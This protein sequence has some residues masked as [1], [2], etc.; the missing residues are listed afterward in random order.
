MNKIDKN[1]YNRLAKLAAD[2]DTAFIELYEKF[3]PL[4]YGMIF[5]RI[6]DVS[7]SDDVVSEIFFKV[8]QNLHTYNDKYN[9]SAW[10][11]AIATNTLINHFRK[12]N[13]RRE[14]SWAEFFDSPA[15]SNDQPEEKLLSDERKA[16]LLRAVDSLTDRQKKIIELKYFF[17]LSNVN[18]AEILGINAS[19]VGYIHYQAIKKL[20]QL[21]DK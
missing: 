11:F 10:L 7:A 8:S 2:D 13:R 5:N 21:L 9:F 20:R 16:T 12:E 1:Y 3:F 15:P 6:K 4:V 14:E 19:N 17:E 18:I